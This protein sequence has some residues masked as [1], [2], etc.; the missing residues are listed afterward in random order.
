[1]LTFCGAKSQ[2]VKVQALV[3]KVA[4]FTATKVNPVTEADIPCK[5]IK[6]EPTDNS[7][8]EVTI[9]CDDSFQDEVVVTKWVCIENFILSRA[10]KDIILNGEYLSDKHINASQKLLA[11][12][13]PTL[14]GFHLTFKQTVVRKWIDNYVQ[15]LHCR[16]CH[17]ITLS[18][19][20][21]QE[22]MVNV[23]DSMFTDV[24]DETQKAIRK[25]FNESSIS[26]SLP[27]VQRQKGTND[28]GLF[29]IAF[30]TKLCFSH[31]PAAVSAMEYT[32]C[33]FRGHLIACL[34]NAYFI[35]FP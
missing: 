21:C 15:I 9:D 32:Q 8:L 33:A 30:A 17:W 4:V 7:E 22:G 27:K 20:G 35:D 13:F 31:N 23:Y 26:F 10:D 11:L 24:D 14:M 5:K 29:A 25:V 1:M 12:Q 18:T 28:C 16:G 3:K 2:L 19:I 34:E 6:I